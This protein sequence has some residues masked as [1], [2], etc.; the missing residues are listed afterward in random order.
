L[1]EVL[2]RPRQMYSSWHRAPP[3]C[4]W[5]LAQP[6]GAFTHTPSTFAWT[7]VTE[8]KYLH[9]LE[10]GRNAEEAL[11]E[12]DEGKNHTPPHSGAGA[13]EKMDERA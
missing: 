7:A 6:T 4:R 11:T 3:L 12:G 2:R 10:D 9:K 5:M 8:K 1:C 13:L